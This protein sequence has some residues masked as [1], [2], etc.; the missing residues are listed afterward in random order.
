MGCIRDVW[1]YIRGVWSVWY[2]E[3]HGET[4]E[5]YGVYKGVWGVGGIRMRDGVWGKWECIGM[6]GSV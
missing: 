5:I 2:R 3:I 6:Y 4:W 1:R